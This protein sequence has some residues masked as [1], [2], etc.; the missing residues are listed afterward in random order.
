MEEF[1][2]WR[3][4]REQPEN[5]NWFHFLG[6]LSAYRVETDGGKAGNI[7]HGKEKG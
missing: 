3:M 4:T 1:M 2:G 7:R 5:G 6:T